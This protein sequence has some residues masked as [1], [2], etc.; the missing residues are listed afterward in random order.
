[1]AK[2]FISALFI[3]TFYSCQTQHK[4]DKNKWAE[5]GDLMTFPNRK[6]MIDD[7]TKNI[8]LKGKSYQDIISLLGQPQYSLDSSMEIGYNIDEDYGSD[9]DPIYTR[10][11]LLHFD[12]DSTVKSFEV[13]EW[14]K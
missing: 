1:M 9:I 12:K 6:A 7:L 5:V 4:F 2:F 10:S 3:V 8:P 13:K 11:L 14:K